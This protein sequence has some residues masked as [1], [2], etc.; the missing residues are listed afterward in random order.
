MREQEATAKLMVTEAME[1]EAAGKQE[2]AFDI[3]RAVVKKYPVTTSAA[4]SQYKIGA[5]RKSR[6]EYVK[7]F[8]SYQIFVDDYKQSSAFSAAI[9]SQYEI[10]KASQTGEHKE[11]FI[12]I[13]RK[14][15]RSE[16]LNMYNKVI[17]NAPYSEYAPQAQFAIGQVLEE[18]GKGAEATAAYKKVVASYPKSKLAADS[19]FRI[20]EIGRMAV[21]GG[22]RNLANVDSSRR[23]Y[24]DLV[25]GFGDDARK[26]EARNRVVQFNEL[27]AKKAFDVGRFYEKQKKYKSAALYYRRVAQSTG[28]TA[29]AEAQELSLIHI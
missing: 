24:E 28:T 11:K 6:G 7:A 15:Q 18:D 26:E 1:F 12:G 22:S 21:E 23:A 14:V 5:I 20:A 25:I 4:M 29:A 19:Q 27:E 2:K 17:E 16:V 3:Y 10:A 9:A 13:S 8:E